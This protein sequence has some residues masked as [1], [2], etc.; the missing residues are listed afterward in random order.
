[1][2]IRPASK[3]HIALG[4]FLW[5]LIV[6]ALFLTVLVPPLV[7]TQMGLSS[8]LSGNFDVAAKR[9]QQ[10]RLIVDPLSSL[11]QP[12]VTDGVL[13]QASL[14]LAEQL[15][16]DLHLFSQQK[17][18]SIYDLPTDILVSHIPNYL[19][20]LD[21][22]EANFESSIVVKHAFKQKNVLEKISFIKEWLGAL[23]PIL[24]N[25]SRWIVLLQNDNELR[26]TGGFMGSYAVITINQGKI[27]ELTIEDIYDADG[28][29]SGY[30]PAPAGVKEYL[31]SGNGLR[32]P[33]ANWH[34]DFPTSA[35]Q[36]LGYFALGNRQE[37]SGVIAITNSVIGEVLKI[38]GPLRLPDYDVSITTDTLDSVLQNR[39]QAFFPG[40]IQKKHLLSQAKNQLLAAVTTLTINDWLSLLATLKSEIHANNILFFSVNEPLN[41]LFDKY[42]MSGKLATQSSN[43]D[44]LALIESN[45]GINKS[46]L[47]Q[48]RS[49]TI[50][51]SKPSQ[52]IITLQYSNQSP[53][54]IVFE[55]SR[56]INYL[57]LITN[58][59]WSL[60][61]VRED[62]NKPTTDWQQTPL[63]TKAG[64]QFSEAG[65]LV[66][67]APRSTKVVTVTYKREASQTASLLLVKQP[68]L[69]A[70]QYTIIKP[71]G[72]SEQLVVESNQEFF[73]H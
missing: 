67:V 38:T 20:L 47:W 30:F 37:I 43:Q 56:Y 66:E 2:K 32:L 64:N 65:G 23:S 24:S 21:S 44:L 4:L 3:K 46:N 15:A 29:F 73:Y 12:L 26:A 34:P 8:F 41:S 69:P 25:K 33:D 45:V 35:Q 68:G 62:N 14:S 7:L 9:W 40:S 27:E 61:S 58:S 1:M 16:N 59:N 18:Q 60:E 54:S 36:V 10:A 6:L 72:S 31:S 51:V 63:Q 71:D 52:V 50:D 17:Q 39:P 49:V 42:S 53:E 70:V 57:R 5:T 48:H 22:I 11:T 19:L 28:Q 13:W 55:Q